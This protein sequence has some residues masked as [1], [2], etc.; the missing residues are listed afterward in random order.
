MFGTLLPSL[1][2]IAFVCIDEAH[3]VSHWSHN[4]RPSYLRLCRIIRDKLGVTTILGLTATAP[5]SLIRSVAGR[6]GVAE[7]NVVR[8]PLLPGNLT[9]S[10]S[11]DQDRDRAL[12]E[13]L[14][15]AGSLG[16]CESVIVY[17]TRREECERLATHIRY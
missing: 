7:E 4:F 11:R 1:T 3:C 8:G 10:E 6:L 2:P 16:Q 12:L 5:E 9:L 17:C 15:E 13:M 14:S